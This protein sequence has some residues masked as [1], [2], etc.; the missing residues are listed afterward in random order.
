MPP[1]VT[2]AAGG[3]GGLDIW[4][5]LCPEDVDVWIE[6]GL[7]DIEAVLEEDTEPGLGATGT[8]YPQ[9]SE[10][11]PPPGATGGAGKLELTMS[12]GSSY[13]EINNCCKCQVL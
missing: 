4:A 13:L 5:G 12:L 2:L 7:E 8:V 10:A 11:P 9:S 1:E 6:D 3:G